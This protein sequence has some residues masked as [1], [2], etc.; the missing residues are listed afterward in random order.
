MKRNCSDLLKKLWLIPADAVSSF[1]RNNDL[2][3]ASSLAFSATLALIPALFLLTI[4]LGAAIGSSVRAVH[5][6]Q[7]LMAQL[8]PAYSQVILQ[9]VNFI[10]GHKGTIGLLNLFV[11]FWSITPLVADMRIAL[12]AIF[13]KKPSRPY[14]LEKLFDAA[15]GMVFLVGLAAVSV[16]GIFF[17]VMERIRPLRLLPGYLEETAFFVV[18]TG[19]VLALYF[20]FSKR[21]RFRHLLAGSVVTAL[22]WFALRPAFH[23]FLT[24][25]PGYGFA[26]GSFKS[27]FVIIIWI[28]ISLALFL[29]GAETAAALGRAE[30][31]HI[32]HLME[33][34]KTVPAGVISRYVVSHEKGRVI[35]KEGD[36]G[37]GMFSVLKGRVSIRKEDKEIAVIPQGRSFGG[38]SFLLSSPRIAT[39]V[40]LDD[41]ELLSLNSENI[42]NLMNEFPE[43]VVKMLR[44]TALRVRET[45]RVID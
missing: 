15:I 34:R 45:N 38:L 36:P 35:F 41:V 31:V 8:I 12:G 7:E 3:A 23:L 18:V 1:R 26:F 43:F 25:N 29:L 30:T 37:N 9:E 4:L 19:V 17:T 2:T 11:L 16:A 5:K 33:G 13:R 39:A 40:A 21:A 22:L 44:E 24:Y 14:L 28:Y 42:N 27:L 20:T 32:M 6:T 10:A